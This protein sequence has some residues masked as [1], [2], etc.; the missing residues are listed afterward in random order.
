MEEKGTVT[1]RIVAQLMNVN[2][3]LQ[4]SPEAAEEV[5]QAVWKADARAEEGL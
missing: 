5:G 3:F 1:L 4:R 2:I